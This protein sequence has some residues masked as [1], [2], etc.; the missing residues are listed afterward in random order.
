MLKPVVLPNIYEDNVREYIFQD[1]L[2][3]RKIKKN[4]IYIN[5][6]NIYIV[7]L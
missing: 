7:T 2:M 4:S 5:L 6:K 3:N 1:S